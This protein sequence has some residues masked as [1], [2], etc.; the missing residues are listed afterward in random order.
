MI[1]EKYIPIISVV[2]RKME[3]HTHQDQRL[4]QFVSIEK[5]DQFATRRCDLDLDRHRQAP[6]PP[7]VERRGAFQSAIAPVQA[8]KQGDLPDGGYWSS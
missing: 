2:W 4:V 7:C 3:V 1:F 5:S 6:F 8:V